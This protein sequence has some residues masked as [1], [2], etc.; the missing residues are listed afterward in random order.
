MGL[1]FLINSLAGGGAERV[2][3]NLSKILSVEKIF[4][5]ERDIKYE[6]PKEKLF[7]LSK[8][9]INTN[10][11]LK[12]LSIPLYARALSQKIGRDS[13]VV[14][15]LERA[16]YVNILAKGFSKHKAFIS[17]RMSQIKGRKK[18]HSYN[19]L[20][21]FL[22]P[23]ADKVICVSKGIANELKTYFGV[24]EEKI[25]VIYNP[26]FLNEITFL[27]KESLD[28]YQS[29]FNHPVI[30]TSGRLTKP[31]GQW[32]LL[33]IFKGLKKGYPGLKLVLL[34]GG[35]LKDYLVNLSNELGL[36]TYVWDKGDKLSDSYD[37]YFLGFQRNPFKF[38]A[39]ARLF[40]F[41]SLWE[42]LPNAL[43][44][45]MA[46]GVSA[47]SSDCR[48]G[49]REILAPDTD[50]EYQTKEPEFAE[51]GVLMPVFEV[52]YKGANEPLDEVERMWIEVVSEFL[53]RDEM[54]KNYAF[55]ARER[56]KDFDMEKI[57]QEWLTTLI[58]SNS[59]C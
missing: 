23:K 33:R 43:I 4:L 52:K 30:I 45:A 15:F 32:Y 56:A 22:Y 24:P 9:S 51:Y 1:Y 39:R 53:E 5:L 59:N 55:K 29:I 7:F 21:K 19:L 12:T 18:F 38:I 58:C 3:V 49:P 25:V 57:A 17:V 31:K 36:R 46:C 8:H 11:V 48:S 6:I 13:I 35:E 14:S 34:G 54:R 47:I 2:T 37:V 44:E 50:I 16:N 26:I 20:S 28:E 41:P 40:V 42:G 27:A 10:P